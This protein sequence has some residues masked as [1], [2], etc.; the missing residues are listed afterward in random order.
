MRLQISGLILV[1][2]CL[3]LFGGAFAW[4]DGENVETQAFLDG[5]RHYEAK[6]YPEAIAAFEQVVAGG[7]RNGKLFYN[8]ANAHLKNGA[9]GPAILWYER[10]LSL[11]PGDPDLQ[12]N[13]TYAR[14]LV[15]DE[16]EQ[17]PSPVLRVLFFWKDMFRIGTLQWAGIGF[18]AAFWCV[19]GLYRIFRKRFLKHACYG[20]FFFSFLI[21][22]TVGWQIYEKNY[23]RQAVILPTSVAVRSGHAPDS[24]E[25]F[26]LHEGTKVAVRQHSKGFLKIMFS[27]D[28]IGW[29]SESSAGII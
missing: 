20:L 15:K 8:L 3:W 26:V 25:L 9:I 12:F 6:A 18:N 4:A 11:I 19:F 16:N 27:D 29:I 23:S 13:L 17:A 22:G 5:V 7:V 28:K 24:T 21:I 10:A 1:I 14:S 2:S